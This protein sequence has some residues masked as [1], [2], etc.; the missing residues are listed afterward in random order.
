MAGQ[1]L[2]T[3]TMPM[4]DDVSAGQQGQAATQ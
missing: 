3:S 2:M 1:I 4:N